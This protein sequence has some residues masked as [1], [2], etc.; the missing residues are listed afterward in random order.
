M[1]IVVPQLG[2][3]IYHYPIANYKP[4]ITQ[5]QLSSRDTGF[6]LEGF[7]RTPQEATFMTDSGLFPDACI[8]LE[9]EDDNVSDRQL[10]KKLKK[11]NDKMA[12]KLGRR[13]RHAERRRVKKEKEKK[14]KLQVRFI[15]LFRDAGIYIQ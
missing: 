2:V 11:W 5:Y 9:V 14:K 4:I 8:L 15:H 12:K 1:Y 10:P 7:P 13:Q 3:S 6:I